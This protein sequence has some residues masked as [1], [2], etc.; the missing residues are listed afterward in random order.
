MVQ[1]RGLYAHGHT[2]SASHSSS[3]AVA[4]RAAQLT[5]WTGW[6]V[7]ST[8]PSAAQAGGLPAR[9][10][11]LRRTAVH[12]RQSGVPDRRQGRRWAQRGEEDARS[13]KA[14]STYTISCRRRPTARRGGVVMFGGG[15]WSGEKRRS[16]SAW[17]ISSTCFLC[18]ST[19]MEERRRRS[20]PSSR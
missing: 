19:C 14:G 7:R 15:A 10:G 20:G 18:C 6:P 13:T 9:G 1:H 17:R 12:A 2:E 5:K 3:R 16:S 11:G 8:L 4:Q